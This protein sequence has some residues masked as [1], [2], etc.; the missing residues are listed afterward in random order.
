[1]LTTLFTPSY[2]GDLERAVWM[3][4]SVRRF[5]KQPLRHVIAVPTQDRMQF[6]QA[7]ADDDLVQLV[8]QQEV[9]SSRFYP[10]WFYPLVQR[11]VPQAQHWRFERHEGRIGWIVQQIV[12]LSCSRWI[13][14]GA[15]AMVDSDLVFTRPFGPDDL[16]ITDSTRTLLRITPEHE[17]SR[18]RRHL[19]MSRDLLG[20]P[21]GSSEHHYM[22]SPAIWYVDWLRALQQH[23]A[24]RA[25]GDWQQPLYAAVDISEYTIYGLFV[26]EVLKPAGLVARTAPFHH[27]VYDLETF[28]QLMAGRQDLDPLR[29][30]CLTLVVQSNLGLP[31]AAYRDILDAIIN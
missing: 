8:E 29:E 17:S 10:R 13:S 28:R 25:A 4:R 1:M 3:R 7:F 30:R 14:D 27:I 18:H 19:L 9:V 12:K 11:L 21:P 6:G 20:L 31:V 23:L 24:Q 16:G 15:V 22:G 2:V 26:E 5:Q